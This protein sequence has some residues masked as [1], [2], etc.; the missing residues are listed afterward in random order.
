VEVFTVVSLFALAFEPVDAYNF[1]VLGL[2]CLKVVG[3][4]EGNEL[5]E[6]QKVGWLGGHFKWVRTN[7]TPYLC[8]TG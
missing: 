7:L 4:V 3:L 5:V 6:G 2:V 1:F 8:K